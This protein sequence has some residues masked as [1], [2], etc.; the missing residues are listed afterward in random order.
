[1]GHGMLVW[2]L[3][4]H[5]PFPQTTLPRYLTGEAGA[6]WEGPW[7]NLDTFYT[8]LKAIKG[9][10][11]EVVV[12]PGEH[13]PHRLA[14][15]AAAARDRGP[16]P[17]EACWNRVPCWTAA[18]L[19]ATLVHRPAGDCHCETSDCKNNLGQPACPAPFLPSAYVAPNNTNTTGGGGGGNGTTGGGGGGNGTW[20]G[21]NYTTG[22]R[23]PDGSCAPMP[24]SAFTVD[25]S[26]LTKHKD[27]E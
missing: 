27:S 22:A 14:C 20:T 4:D 16:P 13:R 7:I 12:P 2:S 21:G 26:A 17:L 24:G 15:C 11:F 19:P 9:T 8:D 10:Y 3:P 18:C 23:N 1:M 25:V 5:Y 6:A